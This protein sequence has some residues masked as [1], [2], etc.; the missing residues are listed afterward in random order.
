MKIDLPPNFNMDKPH[1]ELVYCPCCKKYQHFSF[2]RP[3]ML[4]WCYGCGARFNFSYMDFKPCY[5]V[6]SKTYQPVIDY[7][8]KRRDMYGPP[9]YLM[10]YNH[11]KEHPEFTTALLWRFYYW[12]RYS[13]PTIL[14]YVRCIKRDLESMEKV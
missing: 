5:T 11:W 6:A 2:N 3:R 1:S 10:V 12:D 8:I 9:K 4:M 13:Y 7:P 14:R